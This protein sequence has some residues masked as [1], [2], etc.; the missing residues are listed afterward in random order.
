MNRKRNNNKVT[1]LKYSKIEFK[2][3]KFTYFNSF[4]SLYEFKDELQS[5]HS[6]HYFHDLVLSGQQEDQTNQ[7]LRN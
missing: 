6:S 7:S 2:R 5:T 1:C 4:E 3:S